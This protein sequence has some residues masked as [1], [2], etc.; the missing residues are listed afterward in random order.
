MPPPIAPS[1]TSG[2]KTE[3]KTR[4]RPLR[5]DA[6]DAH[7]ALDHVR[8]VLPGGDE[9]RRQHV[10]EVGVEAHGAGGDRAQQVLAVLAPRPARAPSILSVRSSGSPTQLDLGVDALAAALLEVDRGRLLVDAVVARERDAGRRRSPAR[11]AR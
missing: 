6:G 5:L 9:E 7:R 3:A 8:G 10:R 11:S 2:R 4:V 1:G